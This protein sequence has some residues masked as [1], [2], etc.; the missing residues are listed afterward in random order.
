MAW[1]KQWKQ[2]DLRSWLSLNSCL[3]TQTEEA[4]QDLE[5]LAEH[6]SLPATFSSGLADSAVGEL[7]SS[8]VLRGS[9]RALTRNSVQQV[10]IFRIGPSFRQKLN[11]L[12]NPCHVR[13]FRSLLEFPFHSL[14][15]SVAESAAP[16]SVPQV[17]YT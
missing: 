2:D 6:G 8:P 11:Q 9:I 13:N 5:S 16:T 4:L 3:L 14:F 12:I 7:H 15:T 1:W 10:N 17:L